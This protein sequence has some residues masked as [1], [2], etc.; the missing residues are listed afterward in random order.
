MLGLR[1]NKMKRR[2]WRKR[3]G[4]T[5]CIGQALMIMMMSKC[6]TSEIQSRSQVPQS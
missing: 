4:Q 2:K 1:R 6:L 5:L 3:P